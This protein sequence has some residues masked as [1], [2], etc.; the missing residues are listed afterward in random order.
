M[1]QITVISGKGG[2]GKT[3][4]VASLAALAKGRAVIAD[5]DVDAPDLHIILHPEVKERR[6]FLGMKRAFIDRS[7]CTD[8]GECQEYCRFAAIHDRAVDPLACEGCGAC[9]F[10]CPVGAVAMV[11]RLSGY[12]YISETR[13]GPLVH[14]DL[15]PGEEASGKLVAVVREMARDVAERL[16][17]E[18]VLIDGSPG[19]GCPVIASLTGT[20]LA[21]IVTEPTLSGVHDLE[22]IIGV[23]EH[24]GVL[25][26]VCINKYDLNPE[27]ARKIEELCLDRGVEVV[28]RLPFDTA[29][30]DAMV[31]GRAVVEMDDG[32]MGEAIKSL[33]RGVEM[34]LQV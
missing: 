1:K 28:G 26:L 33:W 20:D 10:V 6:D 3:T 32:P 34:R 9:Q 4:I 19:I 7:L 13:F 8:C 25:S 11:N 21:L 27:A 15:F 2:T 22:R 23:A 12:A 24:F 30:V 31:A 17:L 18:L 16:N 5:C 29:V 14:A